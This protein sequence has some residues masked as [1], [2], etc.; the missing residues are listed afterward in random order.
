MTDPDPGRYEQVGSLSWWAT[1]TAVYE[2]LRCGGLVANTA[3][4]DRA[5]PAADRKDPDA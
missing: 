2:C 1:D 3:V 5:C 4:H